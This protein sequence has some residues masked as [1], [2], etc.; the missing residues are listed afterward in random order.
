M[1][2]EANHGCKFRRLRASQIGSDGFFWLMDSCMYKG[3][4]SDE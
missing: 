1:P 2:E 4:C 3:L